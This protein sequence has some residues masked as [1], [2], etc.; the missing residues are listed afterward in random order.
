[1]RAGEQSSDLCQQRRLCRTEEQV[2]I[3]TLLSLSAGLGCQQARLRMIIWHFQTGHWED[4]SDIK[5][6]NIGNSP[7]S[8]KGF[9]RWVV[10]KTKVNN[11]HRVS[12]S[13]QWSLHSHS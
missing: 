2:L 11:R 5:M 13:T 7:R 6:H 1:M 12:G 4:I 10:K 9:R 8:E 3:G